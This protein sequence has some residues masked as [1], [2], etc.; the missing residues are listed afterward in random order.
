MLP[1]QR[2]YKLKKQ[3][4]D[5][6][7]FMFA[8]PRALRTSLPKSVDL[9]PE[10]PD[11]L[12]QGSI[13]SCTANATAN[14]LRHLLKKEGLDD[15]LPSRLFIYYNSRVRIEGED[16]SEDSGATLRDVC[17]AVATFHA[18]KDEVWPYD[19]SK[20]SEE[21]SAQAYQDANLHATLQYHAV[22]LYLPAIKSALSQRYPIVIGIQ[23]FES[24]ESQQVA[25]T[26]VVPMPNVQ[27]EQCLGGHAVLLVGYNDETRKFIV[28]N[29]WSANWG[30]KGFFEIDYDYVLNPELACDFWVFTMFK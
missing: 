4:S 20:F 29:S 17:K 6:R 13:G 28:C 16:A 8:V 27:T 18:C 9:R 21:P 1:V 5:E 24:F 12:D 11:V 23:I 15:F 19:I 2:K 25:D 26:G 7:D 30:Q 14:S 10:M 22:P 3:E